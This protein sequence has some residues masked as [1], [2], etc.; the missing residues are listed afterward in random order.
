MTAPLE[1]GPEATCWQLFTERYDEFIFGNDTVTAFD[2]GWDIRRPSQQ[3]LA[4][5]TGE[6]L[7]VGAFAGAVVVVALIKIS[8]AINSCRGPAT[9]TSLVGR[10]PTTADSNHGAGAPAADCYRRGRRAMATGAGA[11]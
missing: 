1:A 3:S 7:L 11:R 10:A 8:G 4:R 9:P 6:G 5:R 2:P